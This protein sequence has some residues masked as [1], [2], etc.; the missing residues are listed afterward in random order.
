MEKK[1]ALVVGL[2][3]SGCVA[4]RL[5][6]D[7]GYQVTCFEKESNLG[8]YLFEE[9]RANGVRVQSSGPHIFHTDNESVLAY[10]KRFGSFYPYTHRVVT[11]VS[12]KRIPLP[13]NSRS[14]ELLWGSVQAR[15][16]LA[17]I[18][19]HFGDARRVSVDQLIASKDPELLDLA[20]FVIENVLIDGINTCKNSAFQKMDDSYMNDAFI[21]TTDDDRYYLDKYQFMPADGFT[22]LLE[23]MVDHPNITCYINIDALSR[24]ALHDHSGTILLDGAPFKGPVVFTPSVD[25]LLNYRFG[26]LG[27]RCSTISIEDMDTEFQNENA[28]IVTAK[29]PRCVRTYESKHMTLQD[30][31]GTSICREAPYVSAIY[32]AQEPFEPERTDANLE[33]Y[34]KYLSQLSQYPS[35]RLLGKQACFRN[36][37]I[38]ECVEQALEFISEL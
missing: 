21:D 9:T 35:L 27:F 26:P 10:M 28:V 33:I 3:L 16:L 12:G 24:I 30:I 37:S 4:A 25:M 38:S 31:S 18:Q 32:S 19:A 2:G 34:N 17:H 8:G 13:L 15:N 6:A 1:E 11:V 23:N 22:S 20:R 5:L 29:D 14:L 36:M 7:A